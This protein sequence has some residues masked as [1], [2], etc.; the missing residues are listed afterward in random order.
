MSTAAEVEMKKSKLAEAEKDDSSEQREQL[1]QLLL[2]RNF[3]KREVDTVVGLLSRDKRVVTSIL[4]EFEDDD[5]SGSSA[6][7]SAIVTFTSFVIFGLIPLISTVFVNIFEPFLS[8]CL[9]TG[10][11][12]ICLGYFKVR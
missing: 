3:S 8:S 7:M 6:A 11:T 10:L 2:N 5:D 12:L 9:W 4:D 1:E